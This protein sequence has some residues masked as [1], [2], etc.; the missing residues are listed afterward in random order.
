MAE[1]LTASAAGQMVSPTGRWAILPSRHGFG[2]AVLALHDGP[3]EV[4]LAAGAADRVD[5]VRRE[6][7]E[8]VFVCALA[9]RAR[10]FHRRASQDVQAR[11]YSL[12]LHHVQRGVFR[13]VRFDLL[14]PA[15]APAPIGGLPTVAT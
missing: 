9:V 14:D 6:H 11:S 12:R 13:A 1:V 7:V 2:A 15:S 3:V 5:V 8:V 10:R 4:F